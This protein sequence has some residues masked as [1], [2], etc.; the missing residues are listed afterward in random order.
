MEIS[1]ATRH[2]SYHHRNNLNT[3]GS[4]NRIEK[5]LPFTKQSWKLEWTSGAK[6]N[7]IELSKVSIS[8][9][10]NEVFR[11]LPSP[12][13]SLFSLLSHKTLIFY[14]G[15]IATLLGGGKSLFSFCY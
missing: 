9:Y 11:C 2:E 1:E 4:N 5:D 8:K 15:A 10:Q 3:G 14:L 12:F 13:F 6:H 7:L